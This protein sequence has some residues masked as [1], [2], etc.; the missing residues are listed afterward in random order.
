MQKKSCSECGEPAEVSPCQIVSTVGRA[1][2]QQR[3]SR[4]TAFCTACFAAR[5]DLLRG[6]GLDGIQ[7]PLSDAFTALAITCEMG[8]PRLKRSVL[9]S[10]NGGGR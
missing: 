8:L 3:C 6:V 2:R 10:T 5:I 7:Q 1:P 9:A 4:A